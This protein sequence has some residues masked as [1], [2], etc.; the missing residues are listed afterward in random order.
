MN[1]GKIQINLN[2]IEDAL[3]FVSIAEKCDFRICISMQDNNIVNGKSLLGLFTVLGR[4]KLNVLYNG[5]DRDFLIM[6]H[7]FQ[8]HPSMYTS[9]AEKLKG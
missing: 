1:E 7:K 8:F 2:S 9:L 5:E 3:E 4:G 6:L